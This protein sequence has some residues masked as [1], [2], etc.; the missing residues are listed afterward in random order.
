MYMYLPACLYFLASWLH[1]HAF[2]PACLSV[3]EDDLNCL[4]VGGTKPLQLLS[5][6]MVLTALAISNYR[7]KRHVYEL[8]KLFQIFYKMRNVRI[9]L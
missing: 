1:Q 2:L 8:I 9:M 4:K 5:F 7:N 6:Y 3:Y